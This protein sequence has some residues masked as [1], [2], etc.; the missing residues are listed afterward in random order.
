LRS[1]TRLR[2]VAVPLD[3]VNVD[4]DQIIPARFLSR[5]REVGI[6]RCMFHD[7][8]FDEAGQ[9]RPEFPMNHPARQGARIL[10]ADENFG[11][12]SSRE[13]AVWVLAD[14]HGTVEDGFRCVVAPSFGDIF[15][16]NACKNGL[17]PVRL[18]AEVC[19]ELRRL[20]HAQPGAELEIDLPGQSVTGPD[21][22]EHRFEIDPHRKTCLVRGLDDIDLTLLEADR[23]ARHEAE[24]AREQPW[25]LPAAGRGAPP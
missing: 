3:L 16:N 4:T 8:R 9:P 19:A 10:V 7:L 15:Y 12:G 20:L 1:F 23:I 21:G 17:L 11:C 22:A 14:A 13:S 6:G 18:P 5:P 2:A 25:R 24:V